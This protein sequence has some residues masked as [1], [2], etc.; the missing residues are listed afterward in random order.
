MQ[1]LY[2]LMIGGALTAGAW[3]YA[4][5]LKPPQPFHTRE[6]PPRLEMIARWGSVRISRAR[7]TYPLAQLPMRTPGASLIS[8]PIVRVVHVN[9][10]SGWDDARTWLRVRAA[11]LVDWLWR[12][13]ER[14]LDPFAEWDIVEWWREMFPSMPGRHRAPDRPG[15]PNWDR[16]MTGSMPTIPLDFTDSTNRR[17]RTEAQWA[18]IMETNKRTKEI[19]DAARARRTGPRRKEYA[20]VGA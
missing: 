7:R 20:G 19:R 18:R 9:P 5:S 17:E 14:R 1:F 16:W 13:M 11:T 15:R 8:N 2:G 4:E 10:T 12:P 3:A 6:L